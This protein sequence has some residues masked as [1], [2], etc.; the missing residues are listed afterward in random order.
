MKFLNWIKGKKTYTGAALMIL[1]TLAT[2]GIPLLP[3]IAV[4]TPYAPTILA[5]GAS[6]G[7]VGFADK[8]LGITTLVSKLLKPA[9]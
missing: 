5:L 6:L 7:G 3:T 2:G 1:G 9:A 4:L 8:V